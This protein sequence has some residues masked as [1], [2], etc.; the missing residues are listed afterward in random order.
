MEKSAP[1]VDNRENFR[2]AFKVFDKTSQGFISAVE[3]RYILQNLGEKM[4][5]CEFLEICKAGNFVREG[6]V[7]YEGK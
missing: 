6:R 3:L 1:N 2:K 5:D 4:S 7:Y